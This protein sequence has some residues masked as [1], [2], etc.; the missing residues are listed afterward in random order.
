MQRE[1]VVLGLVLLFDIIGI[2]SWVFSHLRVEIIKNDTH[3]P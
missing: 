1:R 3:P 2:R